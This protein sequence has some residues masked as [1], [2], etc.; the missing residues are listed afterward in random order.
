MVGIGVRLGQDIGVHRRQ[1][2]ELL[3]DHELFKQE[4]LRKR[5]FWFVVIVHVLSVE[6]THFHLG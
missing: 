1:R 3:M 6:I 2:K 4:E 5:A